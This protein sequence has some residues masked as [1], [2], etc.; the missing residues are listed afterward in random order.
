M[1]ILVTNLTIQRCVDEQRNAKLFEIGLKGFHSSFTSPQGVD[2]V[3]P[4]LYV[5]HTLGHALPV[6]RG[7]GLGGEAPDEGRHRQ[8]LMAEGQGRLPTALLLAHTHTH[9][10]S[11][12]SPKE[13]Q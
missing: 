11:G 8:L 12:G 6:L 2:R 1:L 10:D 4:V 7:G 3:L 9:Q 13:E 5:L